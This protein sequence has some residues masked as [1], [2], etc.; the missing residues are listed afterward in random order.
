M[1]DVLT[2]LKRCPK[3]ERN[4]DV[5][6]FQKNRTMPN[7]LE[8]WCRGCKRKDHKKRAGKRKRLGLCHCG[9]KCSTGFS[10]CN[11]CQNKVKDWGEKNPE[12]KKELAQ[13]WREAVREKVFGHYGKNCACC[14]ES[15]PEFLT[16][17]HIDGGG[18][19][20]RKKIQRTGNTF[21]GWLIKN[22]FPEG[23]Q[24]LCFNCNCALGHA[25]YC[26]H[27]RER[28]EVKSNSTT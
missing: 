14:G 12:R 28:Q 15:R 4:L 24:T 25:G 23:F 21:Y 3:C 10:T 8:Y 19:A 17:D 6:Q 9:R 1:F 11:L 16:I 27:E 18:N 2:G 22:N 26:P 13:K 20:H 7:G 5:S